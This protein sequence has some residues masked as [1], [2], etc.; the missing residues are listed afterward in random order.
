MYQFNDFRMLSDACAQLGEDRVSFSV[1][2]EKLTLTVHNDESMKISTQKWL[3]K[4][5]C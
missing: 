2:F 3:N 1:D 5:A 4:V